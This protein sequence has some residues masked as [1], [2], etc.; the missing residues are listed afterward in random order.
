MAYNHSYTIAAMENQEF[1][2]RAKERREALGLS[3]RQVADQVGISQPA[4]AK[5]EAGGSTTTTNGFALAAALRTSLVWLE[6]GTLDATDA[7][8]GW[9]LLDEMGRAKTEAF[10]SGLLSVDAA[11]GSGQ[12][13]RDTDRPR[14]D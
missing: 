5:I 10:I 4:I 9:F 1:G 3:Q 8:R 2:L 13:T 7:P 11:Q 6:F 12:A 14:G